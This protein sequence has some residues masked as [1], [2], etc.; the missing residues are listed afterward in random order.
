MVRRDDRPPFLPVPI[1]EGCIWPVT[2][3]SEGS[4]PVVDSGEPQT[5]EEMSHRPTRVAFSWYRVLS[6]LGLRELAVDPFWAEFLQDR[7]T[8][9]TSN[10]GFSQLPFRFAEIS[11]V[12]LDMSVGHSLGRRKDSADAG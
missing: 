12:I 7:L 5:E 6:Y 10:P 11:K 4:S 2:S 1:R 8:R 9:E 3:P